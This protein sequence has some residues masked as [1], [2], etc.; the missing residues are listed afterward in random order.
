MPNM[1]KTGFGLLLFSI[2]DKTPQLVTV[3]ELQSNPKI[4]KQAGSISFPLETV[5]RNLDHCARDTVDR[6][7]VEELGLNPGQVTY[8]ITD[9]EFNLIP[10]NKLITTRYAYG[11]IHS[12]EPYHINPQ[13]IDIIFYRWMPMDD[14][15]DHPNTRI[16]TKPILTHFKQSGLYLKNLE[17]M[18][19]HQF[20]APANLQSTQTENL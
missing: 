18:C 19:A 16:E 3:M 14:L 13:D 15:L 11:F 5:D 20:A 8:E 10:T 6:L 1:P 12:K 7:L 9:A 17:N 2:I 4:A